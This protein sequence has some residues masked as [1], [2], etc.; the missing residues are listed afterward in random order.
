MMSE[1]DFEAAND[2]FWY[3]QRQRM[4]HEGVDDEMLDSI[5]DKN[6]AVRFRSAPYTPELLHEG[7][8]LEYGGHRLEGF[9]TPGHTP[10]HMCFYDRGNEIMFLGD[11]VLFDITPNITS[12]HTVHNALGCYLDSLKRKIILCI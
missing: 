4:K 1:R 5:F 7:D 3:F 9:Y 6:P 10:G 12:R 2:N 11:H 8:I